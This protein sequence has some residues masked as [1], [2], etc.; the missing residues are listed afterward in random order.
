MPGG[1]ANDPSNQIGYINP[2]LLPMPQAQ[3][4]GNLFSGFNSGVEAVDS[5]QKKMSEEITRNDQQKTD[6]MANDIKRKLAPGQAENALAAQGLQADQIR[7]ATELQPGAHELALGQQSEALETQKFT[8]MLKDNDPSND[9]AANTFF[10]DQAFIKTFGY[11]PPQKVTIENPNPVPKDQIDAWLEK[12]YGKEA[13]QI[14]EQRVKNIAGKDSDQY[15]TEELA[16]WDAARKIRRDAAQSVMGGAFLVKGALGTTEDNIDRAKEDIRLRQEYANMDEVRKTARA[17]QMKKFESTPKILQEFSQYTTAD[18]T[19]EFKKGTPEYV[20]KLQADIKRYIGT[21]A[22]EAE[23]L[24]AVAPILAAQA[25]ALADMPAAEAVAKAKSEK[26]L[27]EIKNSSKQLD[28]F[29]RELSAFD[30]IDAVKN[31]GREFK[32]VDDIAVLYEFVKTLDPNSAVREGEVKL[33][34]SAIPALA[35]LGYKMEALVTSKNKIVT[36]EVR[37]DIFNTIDTLKQGAVQGIKPELQRIA[38]VAND[39]GVPL[40]HILKEP[41]LKILWGTSAE[42]A[43]ASTAPMRSPSDPGYVAPP[44]GLPVQGAQQGY[45]WRWNGIDK[46]VKTGKA[47]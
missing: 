47:S 32:N 1:I 11:A 14:A 5:F 16:K 41:L 39:Q 12:N 31:S 24:K 15:V 30:K 2:G 26:D 36:P 4:I 43:P 28:A 20:A 23:K 22:L 19:Q 18:K 17:E 42:S 46:F 45:I 29:E 38:S 40:K 13:D 7:A 9:D 35:G 33:S 3:P 8:N 34:Q 25:K 6:L 44:N 37:R 21:H 27:Q 10:T